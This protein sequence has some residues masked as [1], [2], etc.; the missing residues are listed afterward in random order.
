MS[1]AK[2][3]VSPSL[4]SRDDFER[5]CAILVPHQVIDPVEEDFEPPELTPEYLDCYHAFLSPRLPAGLKLTGREDLGYFAWEEPFTFGH[6]TSKEYKAMKQVRASYEDKFVLVS[7]TQH[8]DEKSGLLAQA[9]R[10]K[11]HKVFEIPLADLEVYDSKA[12]EFN[13]LEDYSTWFVNFGPEGF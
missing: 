4:D 2:Q 12:P 6:G 7:L 3:R 10:L 11:D 8:W 5:I 9:Q 13:L 1:K